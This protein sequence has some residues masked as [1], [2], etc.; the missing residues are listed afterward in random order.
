MVWDVGAAVG[1]RIDSDS[2]AAIP[3]GAWVGAG[4]HGQYETGDDNHS[5]DGPESFFCA[6]FCGWESHAR[7][8]ADLVGLVYRLLEN[9]GSDEGGNRVDAVHSFFRDGRRG[10]FS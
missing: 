6:V 2:R 5:A 4:R 3:D 1:A 9:A 8:F 10:I 7:P